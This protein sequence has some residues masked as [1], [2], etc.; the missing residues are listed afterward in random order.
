[1]SWR[2]RPCGTSVR[3]RA[4]T[5][6]DW[7]QSSSIKIPRSGAEPSTLRTSRTNLVGYLK[8]SN[9]LTYRVQ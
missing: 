1:M 3:N 8:G 4:G 6:P 5:R 2:D 7:P 9:D